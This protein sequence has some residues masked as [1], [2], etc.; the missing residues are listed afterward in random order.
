MARNRQHELRQ[1]ADEGVKAAGEIGASISSLPARAAEQ[2]A[3]GFARMFG[4]GRNAGDMAQQSVRGMQ[5][6]QDWTGVYGA[7]YR[8]ISLEYAK[9]AQNQLQANLSSFFRIMQ[10]RTP[11]QLF[12]AYNRLLGENIALAL[13]L[14]GRVAEV[15]KAVVD[16][17]AQKITEAAEQR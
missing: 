15:S 7:G 8:D 4:F 11:D 10:C 3:D 6:V 14:N 13:T 9:W 12:T 17:T 1:A 16:R 2:S 5:L